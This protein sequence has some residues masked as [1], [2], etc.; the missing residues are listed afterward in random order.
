MRLLSAIKYDILSQYRHGFYYA[1]LFIALFYIAIIK[2]LPD[3][4]KAFVETL[5]LFSDPGVLGFYFIGGIVLLEKVQNTMDSLFVTPFRI[6]EYIISKVVSLLILT[7]LA[8]V[9]ITVMTSGFQFNLL[10]LLIGITLSSIFFTLVGF[11]LAVRAKTL[12]SYLFISPIYMIVL[13]LPVLDYLTI[14]KSPIFYVTPGYSALML[15]QGAF[16]GLSL[17]NVL[18]AMTVLTIWI[19]ISYIWA[20][21]SFYKYIVLK[22]GGDNS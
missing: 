2:L 8:S 16:E 6:S 11:V 14:F 21:S 1:Y 18:Y 5:V 15:I 19:V 7:L 22:I 12:N 3:S 9:L 17:F 13:F 4:V 20:Y 10:L